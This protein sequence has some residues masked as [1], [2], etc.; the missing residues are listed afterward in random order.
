MMDIILSIQPRVV[1]GSAGKSSDEIVLEL[2]Q[3]IL[4]DLPQ[5]LKKETGNKGLFVENEQGLIPSL[6]T[7]LLQEI[8]RFNKLLNQM[9]ITLLNI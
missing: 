8:A 4:D 1:S 7:V 2:S 3:K 5:T 9:N 6:S